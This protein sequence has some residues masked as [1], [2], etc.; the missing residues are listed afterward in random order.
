M[1]D[2]LRLRYDMRMEA[3][4]T[5]AEI[6]IY[7]EI[8]N[9][10]WFEDEDVITAKDFDKLLKDA[11]AS[12]ANSL[13]LR[14][15][16]PGG[17]VW[18][19]VAMRAMLMNA[20][21]EN[22]N[23]DIEGLCASAATLFVCLPNAHVRIAD[24]SEFMIHNPSCSVFGAT[25]DDMEKMCE[26]LRKMESD[27]HAMYAERSGQS[28]E[29]IK[30]WMDAETWFTAREAVEYGFAD[31]V[32]SAGTIAACA[33]DTL[34]MCKRMYRNMPDTI[35]SVNTADGAATEAVT[36]DT[37]KMEVENDM[38]IKDITMEQLRA[39]NPNLYEAVMQMGAE[40]ERTRINE[41]DAMTDEGFEM[42]ASE[43]KANGASSAEF[44]KMVV[45]ERGKRKAAFMEQRKE[46]VAQSAAVEGGACDDNDTMDED[47]IAQ[48][49]KEMAA[50]ARAAH[51]D[52]NASMY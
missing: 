43:A 46:E 19:A 16:S 11:K 44:L 20:D 51:N 33:S 12:G 35:M 21:F 37:S 18:Q 5:E 1:P 36:E 24:G 23:V 39:E 29:Q 50:F 8:A 34:D 9:F 10:K 25:A 30:A 4:H 26:R 28:E 2:N 3:E 31:E 47:A 7:S 17:S 32:L 27:D 22:I 49:A 14:I 52:A 13:R 48:N 42:I 15:N 41:I 38:E 6:M 45:A 40:N